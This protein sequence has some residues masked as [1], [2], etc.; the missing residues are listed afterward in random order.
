MFGCG[1]LGG[2]LKF[3][4]YVKL[5]IEKWTESPFYFCLLRYYHS[6]GLKYESQDQQMSIQYWS[7]SQLLCRIF[8]CISE[9]NI[10][11]VMGIS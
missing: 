5:S 1:S 10:L 7:R 9:L 8:G 3:C 11:H 2:Y 4:G 6:V